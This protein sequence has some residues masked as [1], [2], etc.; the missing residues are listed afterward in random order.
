MDI[1][2]AFFA[3][4]AQVMPDGR[5]NVLG[6]DTRHLVAPTFPLVLP[7]IFLVVK[8]IFEPEERTGKHRLTAQM[9]GP[10]EGTKLAPFIEMEL[11]PPPPE[12]PELKA[13]LI[14]IV[15]IAGMS[16]PQAG[17]YTFPVSVDGQELKTIGMRITPVEQGAAKTQEG[18][19]VQK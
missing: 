6:L 14:A 16:F 11:V 18:Q 15:Q 7:S 5:M 3:E 4:H 19:L 17:S 1:P 2:F 10:D 8:V 12:H 9:V 13:A